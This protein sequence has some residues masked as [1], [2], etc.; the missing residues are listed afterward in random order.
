MQQNNLFEQMIQSLIDNEY[1]ISNHFI[2]TETALALKNN[3]LQRYQQDKMHPA[4]IGK[5][6]DYAKNTK[7]RGD[8]ISWIEDNTSNQTEQILFEQINSFIQYLN[9]TCYTNINS[10]EFH[11]AFYEKGSFY[12]KHLDQFRADR[13]RQFSL[14]IYLNDDWTTEDEGNLQ[15][16]LPNKTISILPFAGTAVLFKSDK[17]EHEV[18]PSTTKNRLSIAGWLKNG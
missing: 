5:N 18:L 3:L 9:Q 17:I 11:Y 1:A 2:T 15:L 10:Y 6:F 16:Y 12:K 4:G 14:V 7:V 8:V 13:A